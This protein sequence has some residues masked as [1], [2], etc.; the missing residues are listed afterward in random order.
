MRYIVFDSDAINIDMS[1]SMQQVKEVEAL[2]N[3]GDSL[4][5]IA[6]HI[7]RKPL[8]VA[9]LIMDRA[10]LEEIEPRGNGIFGG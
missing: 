6:K 3:Q 9:L 2:C 10:E 7:K 8:E 5:S 4:S 1:F